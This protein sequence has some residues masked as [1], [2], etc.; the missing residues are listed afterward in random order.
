[1]KFST[2]PLTALLASSGAF[3]A[4]TEAYVY[5]TGGRPGWNSCRPPSSQ[6][7]FASSPRAEVY[8]QRQERVNQAF[9]DLQREINASEQKNRNGQFDWMVMGPSGEV[10]KEAVKKWVDKAFDLAS[11]FNQDFSKTPQERETNDEFLQK[12]REWIGRMYTSTDLDVEGIENGPPSSANQ[13]DEQDLPTQ[14]AQ[15]KGTQTETPYSENRSDENIFQVVVDLPGV[16]RGDVDLTLEKD[17][18]VVEAERR[19]NEEGQQGRS[20]LKKIALIEDEIEVDQIEAK[21]T[22]GV[23]V[24]SAPKKKKADDSETKRKIP[25]A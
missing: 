19:A 12:S 5:G 17:Y 2:I 11:E 3:L 18:L 20:Y 10:D 14:K 6:D 8:R 21:L 25:L 1:M 15:E 22:N 24:V 23:L 9:R 7:T 4:T 16:E 13:K